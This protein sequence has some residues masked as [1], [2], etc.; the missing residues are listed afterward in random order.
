M[1]SDTPFMIFFAGWAVLAIA[2]AA[3]FYGPFSGRLKRRVWPVVVVGAMVAFG[4]FV[5]WQFTDPPWVL[6]ALLPVIA[7]INI[8]MGRFCEACGAYQRRLVTAPWQSIRPSSNC[9]KCG[10]KVD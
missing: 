10:A 2:S 8:K 3:F 4:G 9:I 6:L 1:F 7:W 5:W